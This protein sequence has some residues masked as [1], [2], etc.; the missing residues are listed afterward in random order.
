MSDEQR[1]ILDMLA[2]GKINIDEAERLLAAVSKAGFKEAIKAEVRAK[3][4]SNISESDKPK[5]KYMRISVDEGGTGEKRGQRINIKIP[6]QVLRTGMKLG[7][8]MPERIKDKI[9]RKLGEKG[10]GLNLDNLDS[11]SIDELMGALGEMNID[12]E[13][14]NDKIRIYCE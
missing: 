6:L 9:S 11:K 12:I 4:L 1:Q 3:A 13:D 14:G 10:I 2:E 7:A 5:P 8:V